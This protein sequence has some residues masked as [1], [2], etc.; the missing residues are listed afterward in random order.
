MTTKATK[1]ARGRSR[2]V[3]G[4]RTNNGRSRNGNHHTHRVPGEE[5]TPHIHV[6]NGK[7]VFH[8]FADWVSRMTGSP[9]GFICAGVIILVWA[10]TGPL[11]GFGDAW[12]LIINTGTT[13]VTFLMIFLVQATQNRDSAAFHLKLDELVRAMQGASN[14]LL[15]MEEMAPQELQKIRADYE[16]LAETERKQT[17]PLTPRKLRLPLLDKRL[18]ALR[19]VLRPEQRQ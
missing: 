18:H 16:K 12:Q 15:D 9:P 19:K 8:R 14:Q 10:V 3:E 5:D 2:N 1:S 17:V 4:R 13:V 11:F 7:S 6:G